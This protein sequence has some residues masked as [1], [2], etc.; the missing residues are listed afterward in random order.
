[1]THVREQQSLSEPQ[2]SP[3]WSM[4]I[5]LSLLMHII[6][7]EAHWPSMPSTA[8]QRPEQQAAPP[9]HVSPTTLQ[10]SS[11]TQRRSS[12]AAVAQSFP[13]QS[14]ALMHFS[15]AGLQGG[16][17]MGW[18][19]PPSTQRFSQQS[20]EDEHDACNTPHSESPHARPASVA[21]Q[22]REQHC[23]A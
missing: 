12:S 6:I 8:E 20:F 15:P 1:M 11:R 22:P 13:Q 16:P 7:G 2:M 4:H 23:P 19:Q 14:P 21:S 10:P 17:G 5:P 3:T 18:A 9:E